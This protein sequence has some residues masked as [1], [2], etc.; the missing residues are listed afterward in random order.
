MR[1]S[2]LKSLLFAASVLTVS[3]ISFNANALEKHSFNGKVFNDANKNG[4][5]DKGEKGI[6]GVPVSDG[7]SVVLTDKKGN[8]TITAHERAR[9]ITVYTPQSYC[10]TTRFFS[11]IR[12]TMAGQKETQALLNRANPIQDFGLTRVKE[13]GSFA[14]MSDIEERSYMDWIDRIKAYSAVHDHDFFAITGDICYA[15]GLVLM[16]KSLNDLTMGKRM[17]YTLG[18][19]DLIKGNEDYLGNPYGER[20]FED[21]FGPSWYAFC[22]NG[23]HFIITPMMMGDAKPSYSLSDV[24]KWLQKYL[25][26][27]P[28]NA[29]IVIF[30]HDANDALIPENAN[31]AAFVYGHHHVDYRTVGETGV[32]FYCSM[33]SNKAGN[34]HTPAALREIFF[35]RDG[36]SSTQFHYAPLM[37]HIASHVCGNDDGTVTLFAVV[38]DDAAEPLKVSVKGTA[39]KPVELVQ[40]DDMTWAVNLPKD[41]LGAT[42]SISAYFSDGEVAISREEI[43]PSLRW[44]SSIGTKTAL[45]NP[46]LHNGY[47][48]IS[49][50]DNENSEKCGIYA[51]N[52]VDG[53]LEWFCNTGNSIKGDFALVDGIIYAGDADNTCYAINAKDGSIKWQTRVAVQH[54]PTFT[55]GVH[56]SNGLVYMGSGNGL[57]ALNAA[58]GSTVWKNSHKH[59]TITNVCTNKTAAGALLTNGYWVG[60]FCY[61]ASTGEFLW[62]NKEYQSRYSTCT[63]AVV[64]TTFIYAGYNSIIQVGA[65]SGAVLKQKEVAPTMNIKSEPLIVGD[66]LFIGTSTSGILAVN[67]E[68]FSQAWLYQT[69]PSLIYTSPYTKNREKTVESSP[70]AYGENIIVGANDGYV[71][72]LDQKNGRFKWRLDIGLPVLG[73]PVVEGETLYV[74]DFNGTVLSYDLT[75]LK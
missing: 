43:E 2:S 6:A 4:I 28:E 54:Y 61:D 63:P 25:K 58:D 67:M 1:F 55:E 17:V 21:C 13:S 48:F 59:G 39:A 22:V 49:G 20:N 26:V 12:N 29:P 23:V 35:D 66:K 74:V 18:N 75:L 34:D 71:Y 32:P 68:D 16:S 62:E 56:V 24:Q 9:F 8:Y 14:H 36:I 64:D 41:F 53:T 5:Q 47:L 33:A 40:I 52:S 51:L 3:V 65:R 37:N 10:P 15:D 7:F 44:L 60:R 42:Y 50:I 72:C 38:Y 11:D 70:V 30:N 73:K 69:E 45:S 19:H 57:C 31:V 46:V 27:I